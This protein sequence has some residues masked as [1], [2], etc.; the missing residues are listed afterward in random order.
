M[1]PPPPEALAAELEALVARARQMAEA[2]RFGS[3][4]L[5]PLAEALTIGADQCGAAWASLESAAL[6]DAAQALRDLAPDFAG[7]VARNPTP[8]DA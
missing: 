3:D 6:A 8:K 5:L 7:A 1:T 2:Q 4:Y